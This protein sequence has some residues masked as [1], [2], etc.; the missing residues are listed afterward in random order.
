MP[1]AVRTIRVSLHTCRRTRVAA[2]SWGDTRWLA[3][4]YVVLP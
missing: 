4:R 2:A 1:F 3:L